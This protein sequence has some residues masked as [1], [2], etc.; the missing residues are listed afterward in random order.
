MKTQIS[1][2][3][4]FNKI[5]MKTPNGNFTYGESKITASGKLSLNKIAFNKM[6]QFIEKSKIIGEGMNKLA[7]ESVLN[8]IWPEWSTISVFNF[9]IGDIVNVKG[10]PK[11][12]NGI[13]ETIKGSNCIVKFP[14]AKINIPSHLIIK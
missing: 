7:T 4:E 14:T 8:E 2:K 3:V 11:Y 12:S 5:T 9:K 13:L 10:F 6:I 1:L